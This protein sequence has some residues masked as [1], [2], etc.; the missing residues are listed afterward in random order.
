MQIE[1]GKVIDAKVGT[2]YYWDFSGTLQGKDPLDA[3]QLTQRSS[4][5]DF[6]AH[7]AAAAR[8]LEEIGKTQL[9]D[10]TY[11]SRNI[12]LALDMI[13]GHIT[14]FYQIALPD[15]IS[16]PQGGPFN[17][18]AGDFRISA[19][20]KDLMI[21]NMWRA[22][23]IRQNI[24]RM[25]AILAG[26]APHI[27][28][29]V[30]GG[31]TKHPDIENLIRIN[32]YIKELAAF[33]NNEYSNDV[34][35]IE[36]AYAQYFNIGASNGNLL[37]VGEFP[38]K[39]RTKYLLPSGTSFSPAEL[40][41]KMISIDCI[42]SWFDTDGGGEENLASVFKPAPEKS[43]AY[44]WAKG[45]LYN[46]IPC[47]VGALARMTVARNTA[48]TGLGPRAQSVLGRY[49]ARLE[50]SRLLVGKISDWL[51]TFDP[52]DKT[53]VSIEL[54]DEGEAIGAAEASNGTVIHYISIKDGR[55]D[56]YNVLDSYSWNLCPI[57]R[58]GQNG[59]MASALLGLN[60]QGPFVTPEILRVARSF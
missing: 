13:Y 27:C 4:G 51:E 18:T 54:P 9:S 12:L 23:D 16:Y 43:G 10:S 24:H 2:T 50:E 37:S 60:A 30:F 19:G 22:F 46:N 47:E 48:V 5:L 1:A 28:S 55:I 3:L 36:T 52:L 39:N 59:P 57:T 25:T 29:I 17:P 7:A 45:A 15:Y 42:R 49:R 14:H 56:K 44:S 41:K 6:V 26:K 40:N 33:I 11:L 35:Q 8:A 38:W 31:K 21:K 34:K 53:T 58:G 32:S 20:V